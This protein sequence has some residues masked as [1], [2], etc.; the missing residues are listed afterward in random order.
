M[1]IPGPPV[2]A[3]LPPGR[4]PRPGRRRGLGT[5]RHARR[6]A[7]VGGLGDPLLRNG[8]AL[9]LSATTTSLV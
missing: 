3:P 4:P 5:G 2:Q 8:H 9:L 6:G 1:R 7:P